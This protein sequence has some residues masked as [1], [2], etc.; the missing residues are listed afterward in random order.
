MQCRVTTE[1]P[2][3]HFLPD[4][5]RITHYRSA[6]G[7]GIAARC[8]HRLLRRGGHAVLRFAAGQGHRL[9]PAVHRRRP[10]DGARPAG[11]PRPRREDEHP[12]SD[13]PG[14]PSQVRG[15][16]LHHASSSTRRPSCSSSSPRQD[17]ATK[18]FTYLA[19]VIV[20]GNP[21]V[22]KRPDV[23]R[24]EPA[25]VPELRSHAADARRQRGS[26]CSSWARRI[27]QV[28]SRAEAAA[29]DRHHVPRRAPVAAGHAVAHLRHA[30]DR[31]RLRPAAARVVL[32]SRCGA[33]P[34]STPRC[35]FSK[36]CP[37]QRLA[38]LRERI[39]NILFQMLLRASN[40][41]GYT[42]YPDNVVQRVRARSRPRPASTCSAFSTRSTG[43]PT[44]R[45]PWTPCSKPARICE[46]AICYTGDILD[47][48]RTKYD[49][50]YYVELAKAAGED[51]R[52]H[53]GHQGHGRTC[54]NPTRPR[55][56]SKRSSR[57]SASR[58]T[59]TRT[60]PP[61]CRPA[62][63][64]KAAEVGLDIADG[65]MAPLSG[66]TSQPNLNTVVE[67][68]RFTPRDTRTR[69]R[70]AANASPATGEAPASSTRRSKPACS[71]ARPTSTPPKCP[72]DNTPTC[73]S[74][75]RRWAWLHQWPEICRMYADVNQLFG[76]IVKVTPSSK[77]VGDMALYLVTNDL[78]VNDVLD[79][80]RELSF[81]E[82][83]VDLLA[84]RMGQPP[85]GFPPE[86]QKRILRGQEPLTDRPGADSAA[87]D[88]KAV[89]A[90][91]EKAI[92][93]P[94]TR[95]EVLSYILYPEGLHRLRRAHRKVCR[96]ERAA[97]QRVPVWAGAAAGS[98]TSRSSAARR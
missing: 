43:C 31:R 9:G 7:M 97:H 13:Q 4:Y 12:V 61:A 67:E 62:P 83:V 81:P 8:R 39:P 25:P 98:R 80:E 94:A 77:A 89:T 17:R 11:V 60:T 46:A 78:T 34:R 32:A 33:A 27:Q 76:D 44:C 71:P 92:G 19:E 20:N 10:A 79:T 96:R 2:A 84:G 23:I 21:L 1:D 56:S 30:G 42:N 57:K 26:S 64:L 50:K 51:G 95:R 59:S 93:R 72:A 45:W 41:V 68:L 14:H 52:A 49:L 15:R 90:E 65:A 35:G 85:G 36:E 24:R 16:R 53:P 88:F 18:L 38:D 75:P 54:A 28:D 55:C 3:N 29:A 37:W 70:A 6:G 86:V 66:G 48:K 91:L 87:V 63:I 74:R 22:K 73:I 82:S 69:L 58:S 5:G 47:P 40:A